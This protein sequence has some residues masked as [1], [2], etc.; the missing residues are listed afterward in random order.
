MIGET[1]IMK[2]IAVVN[3]E[4]LVVENVI[5]SEIPNMDDPYHMFISLEKENYAIGIGW[6]YNKE[7]YSFSTDD[8]QFQIAMKPEFTKE[9]ML[10]IEEQAWEKMLNA[11]AM[12]Q[13]LN[14]IADKKKSR[15]TTGTKK[16]RKQKTKT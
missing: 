8:P 5:I 16:S 2:R 3:K 13:K 1:L 9:E 12:G 11:V 4:T 14:E 6:K 10:F 15:K 7:D